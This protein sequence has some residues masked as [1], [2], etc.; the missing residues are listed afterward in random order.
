MKSY[1]DARVDCPLSG[2]KWLII[3]LRQDSLIAAADVFGEWN[4][5]STRRQLLDREVDL[6][7]LVESARASFYKPF[8]SGH[9]FDNS[10]ILINGSLLVKSNN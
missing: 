3:V 4:V 10:T 1:L 5:Y 2:Q 8:P 7:A 9:N 6:D